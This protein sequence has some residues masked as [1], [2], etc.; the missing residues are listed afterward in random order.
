VV[1]LPKY[2]FLGH[3]ERVALADIS[4]EKVLEELKQEGAKFKRDYENALADS[5]K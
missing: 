5:K 3:K 1:F 2:V 4:V